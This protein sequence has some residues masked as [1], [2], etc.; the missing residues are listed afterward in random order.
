M[1]SSIRDRPVLDMNNELWR[2]SLDELRL[3]MSKATFQTW[4]AQSYVTGSTSLPAGFTVAVRNDYA[5]EWLTHRL[6]DIVNRTV[7]AIAGQPATVDFVVTPHV[8][9]NP[10]VIGRENPID[11]RPTEQVGDSPSVEGSIRKT[12]RINLLPARAGIIPAFTTALPANTFINEIHH[13]GGQDPMTNQHNPIRVRIYSHITQSTFLHVEDALSIGKLRL[14]AGS[15]QRGKG[16][17][18]NAHHF[19]DTADARVVLLALAQAEPSFTYRE[20]KGS[21]NGGTDAISR[22]LSVKAKGDRVYFEL[23]NSPG[24]LT[25]TGAIQPNGKPTAKIT[26][27]FKTYEARR[28][29]GEALAYLQAWDVMRLA[30]Q[31][32]S[33]SG[34]PPYALTP[35]TLDGFPAGSI[36][37]SL[38]RQASSAEMTT[39]SEESLHATTVET[40]TAAGFP[41]AQVIPPKD[42]K[43]DVVDLRLQTNG[44]PFGLE[45]TPTPS[46]PLLHY[47]DGTLVNPNNESERKAF[48]QYREDNG[49]DPKSLATLR[50]FHLQ[51]H[52]AG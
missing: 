16:I 20:Y 45:T 31:Q 14:F 46:S 2:Q 25:N 6:L 26:I 3:Q 15:Y 37:D 36:D 5:K 52:A 40:P 30:A 21:A 4:L 32:E 17:T 22:V 19:L 49:E 11:N 23:K 44:E 48:L 41:S 43:A 27:P 12:G 35:P 10:P 47:Q 18:A 1:K 42:G 7:S 50:D 51:N 8:Q 28:L 34:L 13:R 38:G 29:A 39:S 33:I 9:G 24:Q